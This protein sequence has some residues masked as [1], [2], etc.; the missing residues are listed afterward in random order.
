MESGLDKLK[1]IIKTSAFN[2]SPSYTVNVSFKSLFKSVGGLLLYNER[3]DTMLADQS[4]SNHEI[5]AEITP[6]FQRQNTKWTQEMQK[7]FIEN[8]LCGCETKIQL[9]D[10][11]GQGSDLCGSLVL[12]GLQRLTAIAAYHSGEFPVFDGLF[13]NDINSKGT[14]PRLRLLVDIYQFDSDREACEFY[15]QMN[16]G[17]THSEED[18]ETAY[19]FLESAPLNA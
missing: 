13:W 17:I 15:I 19:K 1:K 11:K 18:L 8:L 5:I 3:V 16:K 10:L 14:F 12:D 2:R 4:L 7:C 9:Y 6:E